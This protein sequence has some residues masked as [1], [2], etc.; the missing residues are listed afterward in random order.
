MVVNGWVV[1]S[2]W[3][4]MGMVESRVVL[5]AVDGPMRNLV[6]V[7]TVSLIKY[8]KPDRSLK[9]SCFLGGVCWVKKRLLSIAG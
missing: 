7:E 2:I 4:A 6:V 9:S 8:V 3:K 5:C 1:V